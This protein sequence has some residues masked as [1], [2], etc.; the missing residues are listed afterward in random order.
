MAVARGVFNQVNL[1][2]ADI[3]Q[4]V[5]FYR[6]LGVDATVGREWPAGSDC[7]HAGVQMPDGTMLEWDNLAF[8]RTWAP[9]WTTPAGLVLGFSFG[10][11]DEVDATFEELVSAGYG[12]LQSPMDAFWGARYAVV[13]DPDGN[14]VGLMGPLGD[15]PRYQPSP[16]NAS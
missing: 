15:R 9:E 8:A 3:E 13:A 7:F 11:S 2:V 14:S 6:H 4:S 5:A 1:V 10:A 16:P 12:S